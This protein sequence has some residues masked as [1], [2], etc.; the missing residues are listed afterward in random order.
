MAA[1]I[2]R[3]F[4]NWPGVLKSPRS[5]RTVGSTPAIVAS[6][7]VRFTH[8]MV[9]SSQPASRG[10][11]GPPGA[12]GT[13]K[14]PTPVKPICRPFLFMFAAYRAFRCG[15]DFP[16]S[17]VDEA[18]QERNGWTTY[19]RFRERAIQLG[20]QPGLQ[21]LDAL[22]STHSLKVNRVEAARNDAEFIDRLEWMRRNATGIDYDA[23]TEAINQMRGYSHGGVAVRHQAEH[24]GAVS[25]A[26][27]GGISSGV[28]GNGGSRR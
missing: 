1:P 3:P 22:P 23:L 10:G 17:R 19:H 21:R 2:N 11:R 14:L 5:Q 25:G 26:Y 24:A 9:R 27:P 13:K 20:I 8:R 6:P 12:G 16:Q 7:A 15:K 4:M 18:A 28:H